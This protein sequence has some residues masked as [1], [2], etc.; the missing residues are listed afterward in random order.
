MVT[1]SGV[2]NA[3]VTRVDTDRVE[4]IRTVFMGTSRFAVPSLDALVRAGYQVVGVVSQPE[5]PAGRGRKPA[6]PPVTEAAQRL[7]L[8][9][10]AP[11]RLRAPDTVAEVGD[12]RPDLIVVA[13]YAQILPRSILA[14][15]GKGCVNVHASLLPRWRGA[16]P[17]HAA[18]LA[19]DE[20][21]GV[22]LMAMEPG[23]DTGPVLAQ[24]VTR[25]EDW[26]TTPGLEERLARAG[27][28][29]LTSVLPCYLAGQ[30]RPVAQDEDRVTYAPII[31]KED[32]L[33]DWGLPARRIWLANRAYRQWPGTYTFW[34]GRLLK[35]VECMPEE[36]P[37]GSASGTIL[38]LS[39]RDIGVATGDGVLRLETVAPEGG[40][41]MTARE[42]VAG[43]R[44]FV[45]SRLG[46]RAL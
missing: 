27:A 21:T 41:T 1:D 40:R 28:A 43:H 33:I 11:E 4:S 44:G 14:L 42:F 22:S 39:N 3:R 5:R 20:F 6:L 35:I 31:K 17:I 18:I 34:E 24:S 2:A 38:A 36:T 29:L 26:D 16:S 10:L 13:A 25:I 46:A 32:G 8:T 19:G 30:I 45:G 23:M 7:G 37:A 12:L 9:V 15:P